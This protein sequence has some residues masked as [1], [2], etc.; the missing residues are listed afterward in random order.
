MFELL[1][2]VG[3]DSLV[4]TAKLIPF[5]FVTYLVMEALEHGIGSRIFEAISRGGKT[6]PFIGALLG[7]IPQCGFSAM[8]AT[9]YSGGVVTAGT[10][11]AV[12]LSTSDEMV[13]VFLSHA[14]GASQMLWI[15]VLKVIVGM[16]VGF[17]IDLSLHVFFHTAPAHHIHDLCEREHCGCDDEIGE[18]NE[19]AV[20]SH[21]DH[22][23]DDHAHADHAHD[24]H[25]F[26]HGHSHAHDHGHAH[27]HAEGG[28]LVMGI[29]RSALHHT[30]QVGFFILI[31][32][33]V[34]G[35]FVEGVGEEAVAAFIGDNPVTAVFLAGLF[36]LIPNCAASVFISE[37]YLEGVLAVPAMLSGL[38]VGGGTGLLVLYRTND[39]LRE[40]LIITVVTYVFGVGVGLIALGAGLA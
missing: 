14:G 35:F 26:A 21:D 38:L 4:D 2:E 28:S 32:C 13:P 5:L 17:L 22:E 12:L 19:A 10:L 30:I 18:A 8:T 31:A 27:A 16:L 40:N 39:N 34:F 3:V 9:L 33:F 25:A 1:Y 11:I 23:H 20:H 29:I 15:I 6:G 7:A 24:D 36:G 37:L